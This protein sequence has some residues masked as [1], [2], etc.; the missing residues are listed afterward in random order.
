MH[1]VILETLRHRFRSNITKTRA[2]LVPVCCSRVRRIV[3]AC[4][5]Q[6]LLWDDLVCT[7]PV[8]LMCQHPSQSYVYAVGPRRRGLAPSCH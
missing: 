8:L 4:G 2:I 6:D 3:Y 1:A 7:Y 5:D